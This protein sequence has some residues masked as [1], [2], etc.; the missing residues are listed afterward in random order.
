MPPRHAVHAT[1]FF[2]LYF[3]DGEQAVTEVLRFN[4]NEDWQYFKAIP[5]F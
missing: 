1:A 4:L 3:D 5:W 2:A